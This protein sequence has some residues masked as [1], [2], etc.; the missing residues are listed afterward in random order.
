MKVASEIALP[1]L[2]TSALKSPPDLV[3]E[4]GKTPDHLVNC[5]NKGVTYEIA[6]HEFLQN[7]DGIASYHVSAGN[8]IVVEPKPGANESDVRLFL[9]GTCLGAILHQRKILAIHASAIEHEGKAVLFTGISGAGKSTT[10]NAF[11]LQG[12]KMLTDDV[13]PVDF[14]NDRP[15]AL[16]GYPQSKLWEDTLER[17]DIDFEELEKIRIQ[18]QKRRLPIKGDFVGEPREVKAMYVL[19]P[20]NKD[21]VRMME[22]QNARRFQAVKNMTYRRY[23]LKEMGAQTYHFV[24]GMKLAQ[25]IPIKSIVRPQAFSLDRVVELIAEDLKS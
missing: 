1:E 12:F 20:H 21:E 6:P 14:R 16:P 13:C 17:L 15:Y 10:A 22:L 23:L 19:R 24:N 9:L 3:I 25:A 7:L 18:V 11:R 4:Q 5:K 8:R 2:L